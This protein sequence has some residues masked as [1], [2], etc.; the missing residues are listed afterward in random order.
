MIVE[1]RIPEVGESITQGLL[2]AWLK[3][4]GD[5]VQAGEELFELETDKVTLAVP[6]EA[7]GRLVILVQEGETVT[8]GQV[9]GKLDTASAGEAQDTMPEEQG[10]DAESLSPAVRRLVAE[11]SLDPAQIPATGKGGRLTKGDVLNFI[12]SADAPAPAASAPFPKPAAQDTME[13]RKTDLRPRPSPAPAATA[14]IL[15]SPGER[16]TRVPMSTMRR[17]IAERM[18]QSQQE[19]AILSTFNEADMS[20]VMDYRSRHKEA[21]EQRHGVRLGL[22]SFFVKAVVDALKTVPQ[23]NSR[24]EGDDIVQLHYYDI[25]VAVSTEQ[26]LVV[27]V[28]RGADQLSFAAIEEQIASYA[29]RA[30]Q[31]RLTL[32][33]LTGGSFSISNGGIFGSLLSTPILNPPQSGILG[34]HKI[35]KRPVAV[36]D[37]VVIRPMMYLAVSYDHRLVDGAQAVT[38]LKRV[39]ECI[40]SPERLLLEV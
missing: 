29:A 1:I 26:G 30:R 33:E 25:G 37:V 2:A 7:A 24:V 10:E 9:V 34:L 20:A 5:A 8:V 6:A 13:T 35:Q 40:E 27:P 17:R 31:R 21:F 23:L 12:Q 18:V 3:E 22:M 38:F 11:R 39:K 4:E 15:A 36:N 28:V 32:E 19:A 16:E 14:Q